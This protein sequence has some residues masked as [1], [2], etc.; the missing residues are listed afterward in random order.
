[1]L[2]RPTTDTTMPPVVDAP[3]EPIN[4]EAPVAEPEAEKAAPAP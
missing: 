4:G 1:V 2:V 3:A